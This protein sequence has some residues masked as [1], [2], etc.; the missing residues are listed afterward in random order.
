MSAPAEDRALVDAG[1]KALA[2][3]S[4]PPVVAGMPES[5][6]GRA[7]DEHGMLDISKTN[8]PGRL[9]DKLKLI[10]GHCDPTVSTFSE[11]SKY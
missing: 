3:D 7:S 9:G 11:L 10:P 5:E 1:L 8:H 6:F 4:G 2:M